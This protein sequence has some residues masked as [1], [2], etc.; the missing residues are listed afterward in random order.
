HRATTDSWWQRLQAHLPGLD[1][2]SAAELPENLAGQDVFYLAELPALP[3]NRPPRPSLRAPA[4][5]DP[6]NARIG[7]AMHRLLEWGGPSSAEHV[8]AVAREFRLSP[9]QAMAASALAQR[10]L[11][12]DGAWAWRRDA[13][14]WQGN[15]VDLVYLGQALRLDRLVQRKDAGH[16]GQWWVLDYK[17][18]WMPELQPAYQMQMQ[19]Y[20][21]AVQ[22]I[23]PGATVKAAFLTGLGTVVP[24]C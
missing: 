13:I 1:S 15:E 10:I 5:E 8:G 9:A 2:P 24:V 20:R 21:A 6:A 19:A 4:D 12:G 23:Y 18:A 14:A 11:K 16:E 3:E 22:L 7:K 17:S